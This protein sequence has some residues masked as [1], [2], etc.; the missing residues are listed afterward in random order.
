M[1][2]DTGNL[3]VNVFERKPGRLGVFVC[4]ILQEG[5]I[6]IPHPGMTVELNLESKS[7]IA[8]GWQDKNAFWEGR[9]SNTE[10]AARDDRYLSRWL[11]AIIDHYQLKPNPERTTQQIP[12]DPSMSP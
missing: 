7:A 4:E 10:T 12:R 9:S 1:E 8:V 6:Q 2:I 11:D 3:V 5:D